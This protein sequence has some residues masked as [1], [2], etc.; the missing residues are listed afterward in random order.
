MVTYMTFPSRRFL[1][2]ALAALSLATTLPAAAAPAD[3]E[4]AIGFATIVANA[5]E[6]ASTAKNAIGASDL[7]ASSRIPAIDAARY[8]KS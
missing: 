1:L 5:G 6:Q 2:C 7:A 4:T 8:A 3:C